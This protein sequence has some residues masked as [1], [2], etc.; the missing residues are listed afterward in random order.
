MQLADL[1]LRDIKHDNP[2]FRRHKELINFLEQDL[3]PPGLGTR[4]GH[5]RALLADPRQPVGDDRGDE[6][7]RRGSELSASASFQTETRSANA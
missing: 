7:V 6:G 5:R 4:H 1:S 2:A 3:R